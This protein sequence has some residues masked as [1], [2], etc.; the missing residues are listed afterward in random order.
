LDSTNMTLEEAVA[1][2]EEIVAARIS[3]L[4]IATPQE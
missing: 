3:E 2:A 1:I 4:K